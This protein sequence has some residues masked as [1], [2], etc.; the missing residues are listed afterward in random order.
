MTLHNNTSANN[1]V[2]KS[3]RINTLN[4]PNVYD[5]SGFIRNINALVRN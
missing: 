5:V 1:S 4:L 2:D 3:V